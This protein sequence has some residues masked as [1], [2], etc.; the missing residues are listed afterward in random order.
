MKRTLQI[1]SLAVFAFTSASIASPS[2][3]GQADHFTKKELKSLAANARTPEDHR[4]LAVYYEEQVERETA[5]AQ[6][7]E[8]ELKVEQ[9][10]ATN[11]NPK[12]PY[13]PINYLQYQLE[14]H[15]Q[16]AEKAQALVAAHREMAGMA[17][18]AAAQLK[19]ATENCCS[20]SC[21]SRH[22]SRKD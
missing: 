21:C 9:A 22:G 17:P 10:N 11:S 7:V 14:H 2:E 4:K 1:L 3:R 5:D 13:G 15:R 20:R 16:A 12:H 19:A 8:Q 6:T 18:I